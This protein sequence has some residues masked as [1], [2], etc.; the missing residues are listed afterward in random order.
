MD[1]IGEL[2]RRL[3]F[4]FRRQQFDRDLEEEMRFHLDMKAR[5]NREAGIDGREAWCAARRQLGN[6]MLLKEASREAWGWSRLEA[7]IQDVRYAARSFRRAPG[8]TAV[9][10]LTLALGIGV[11]TAV[12]SLLHDTVLESLPVSRPQELV[13]LAWVQ[14]ASGGSNF[15][16]PDYRPLLEPESALPGLF[17]YLSRET[18][19]R[20]GSISERAHAHLVSGSYYSTLGVGAF[21]GRT[22]VAADD[23]PSATPVAVLS[24]TYWQNRFARDPSIIGRT[25]YLDGSPFTVVGVTPQEF[26]GVNRLSPPDITY[27]LHAAPLPEGNSYYVYYFARL[28]PHTSVEQARAQIT[29]RFSGLLEG[30]L[31]PHRNWMGEVKLDVRPAATGEDNVRLLLRT[32]LRVVGLC[33]GVVLLICCTNMASLLLARA[34]ARNRE[35]GIRLALGAGRKRIVRQLLTESVMLGIAGG[36]AGLLA[37]YWVHHLLITQ[38]AIHQST[39]IQFRLQLPLLAFTA[40][41]AV[42][43]GVVFGIVPALRAAQFGLRAATR[44]E[45]PEA[46]RPRLGPARTFLAVQMAA[47]VVLL[48]GAILFLRT[49]RNLETVD[50]GFSP[51]QLLLMTVDL[52]ESRFQGDRVTGLLDELMDRVPAV[53]GVRSAALARIVLFGQSAQKSVWVQGYAHNDGSAVAFN[54]VGP[55]FFESVGIHLVMGREF[56]ARDR[57]SAP[58]VAIVNQAFARKYFPGQNPL[59]RRFGD[60]GPN[61]A[62]KYEIIGVVKDARYTSL[63]LPPRPA[64]FQSLWQFPQYPPFVLHV[65]VTGEPGVI[66][67]RVLRE[68]QAIDSHLAV[69]GIR[70]MTGQV[71]AT[72]RQERMFAILSSLFGVL[73]IGLCCVGLYGVTAY[74]VRRRTSEFGIRMALGASRA[75]VLWLVLRETLVL[76]GLGAAAGV[77]AAFWCTR[78][79]KSLLFGLSPGD[80]STFAV[81]VILLGGVA[82]IAAALPAR[83]ATRIDPIEALRYE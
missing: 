24:Y 60:Q 25:V 57:G 33:V 28:Q 6:P 71:N 1:R 18:N 53:P 47:S 64:I 4:L 66:A 3:L 36:C 34:A 30:E 17:C 61:S 12:F 48:I 23:R 65:N 72:L 50:A 52:K 80:P 38:L 54:L 46:G 37:G 31:K 8:F 58:L 41:L 21:I 79:I 40:G 78:F 75:N 74:S 9:A 59:G 29:A 56:S 55:G 20:S 67:A 82:A 83:R 22:L 19:L 14:G 26:Y 51:R 69:Y 63:R 81:A 70:T 62:G 45:P 16:W 2:W 73:A 44:R 5:Q 77:P 7:L 49:L 27:S 10:V 39:A 35:I 32:P 11:N 68:I 76:V 43:T 42:L 15:N 13:Q